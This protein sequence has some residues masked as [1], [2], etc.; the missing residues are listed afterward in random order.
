MAPS[1]EIADRSQFVEGMKRGLVVDP[2]RTVVMTVD[3][4]RKYLDMEIGDSPILPDEAERVV[5]HAKE[6]LDFARSQGM[7]VVHAYTTR[8]PVELQVGSRFEYGRVGRALGLSQL[9]HV[10]EWRGGPDRLEGSEQAEVPAL[11]RADSDVHMV[12]KKSMDA[13]LGSDLDYLLKALGPETVVLTG[14][15]TDTC[16]YSTTFSTSNRG[17]QPVVISDCVASMRGKDVHRL[18]LE[19][20]SRGIAWVLTVEEF[21]EKVRQ[22]LEVGSSA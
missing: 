16:V 10:Q 4:Q 8:R 11:L 18:A 3:M 6:L 21:K 19:V 20:M 12:T 17:Y 7:P 9:P 14:I 2:R 5:S 13:Y 15:N 1:M 22:H